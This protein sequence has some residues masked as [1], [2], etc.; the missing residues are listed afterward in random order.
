ME[1]QDQFVFIPP[2]DPKHTKLKH[3]LLKCFQYI[4][5]IKCEVHNS[6]NSYIDEF[7]QH[8]T[9]LCYKSNNEKIEESIE[10]KKYPNIFIAGSFM[11]LVFEIYF[12]KYLTENNEINETQLPFVSGDVDIWIEDSSVPIQENSYVQVSCPNLHDVFDWNISTT[13]TEY[14]ELDKLPS[15]ITFFNE[16]A[17]NFIRT[18]NACSIYSLLNNFDFDYCKF[19]YDIRFDTFITTH[20]AMNTLCNQICNVS[21]HTFQN[22][23]YPTFTNSVNSKS[24]IPINLFTEYVVI[25]EHDS[26]HTKYKYEHPFYACLSAI[27]DHGWKQEVSSFFMNQNNIDSNLF[28]NQ[29][30]AKYTLSKI[31]EFKTNIGINVYNQEHVNY[32]LKHGGKFNEKKQTFYMP[33]SVSIL[34][35]KKFLPFSVYNAKKK[36]ELK[37]WQENG[38]TLIIN[39]ENPVDFHNIH[40]PDEFDSSYF[41]SNYSTQ[42]I[43][44][45]LL[46]AKI[47]PSIVFDISCPT[48]LSK[49]NWGKGIHATLKKDYSFLNDDTENLFSQV[50]R[51]LYLWRLS[52]SKIIARFSKYAKRGIKFNYTFN[53][54]GFLKN[55]N[56]FN[57]I[58]QSKQMKTILSFI[59]NNAS[60]MIKQS[61]FDYLPSYFLPLF[62]TEE[63]FIHTN[64]HLRVKYV[65]EYYLYMNF[66]VLSNIFI[67]HSRPICL[68]SIET[69]CF[70]NAFLKKCIH[71]YKIS[72]IREDKEKSHVFC[73][74]YEIHEFYDLINSIDFE[75]W[76]PVEQ[77]YL[78]KK[79]YNEYFSTDIH[80][81]NRENLFL[82]WNLIGP[83]P[84]LYNCCIFDEY[85]KKTYVVC[86]TKFLS[87]YNGI[88][89]E[90]AFLTKNPFL[91]IQG[92]GEG[93]ILSNSSSTSSNKT[94]HT[95]DTN[96][97]M[98]SESDDDDYDSD[99]SNNNDIE[100]E[101]DNY[102]D[103]NSNSVSDDDIQQ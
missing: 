19:A 5:K 52:T 42:D 40:M 85:S 18:Q 82:L 43:Q 49:Q 63:H 92:I 6:N 21:L 46:N 13:F 101:S 75:N 50:I 62:N 4:Q 78:W 36:Q 69:V 97:T 35:F 32:V 80:S 96:S 23:Y 94:Q 88:Y 33:S 67:G 44:S 72:I 11:T 57:W 25:F 73:H 86:F 45:F 100:D 26:T 99:N 90:K 79:M 58:F 38:G 16:K 84:D 81:T 17:Y 51:P 54:N 48:Y 64:E 59:K 39:V 76:Q 83:M 31:Q 68:D 15:N 37:E 34:A 102:I 66:Y 71:G 2:S 56:K 98:H 7:F 87:F 65:L 89:E 28:C 24:T 47:D 93:L 10:E 74:L 14:E 103:D 9:S 30:L 95:N 55:S 91:G 12:H 77:A 61:F 1:Q 3:I 8:L 27:E 53:I 70:E 60:P 41:T 29:S 20:N 22:L